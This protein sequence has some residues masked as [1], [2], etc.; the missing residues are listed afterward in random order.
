M[1]FILNKITQHILACEICSQQ[2]FLCE[3]CKNSKL[4][5]P[6]DIDNVIK[7][8]NCLTCYH[9]NCLKHSDDCLKCKRKKSRTNTPSLVT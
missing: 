4:I 5:Y 1:K 8:P 6:F 2:G 7:C 3:L 9:R